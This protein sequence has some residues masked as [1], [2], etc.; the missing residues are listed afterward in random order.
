MKTAVIR[1]KELCKDFTRGKT[2]QS[3]LQNLNL[4]IFRGDFT[5]IMGSSGAGKSTLLYNISTMDIPT[6]GKVF[7]TDKE[8][9]TLSETEICNLRSKYIAFVFQS[10]NLL[11]D[12]TA[13]E[14][15]AFPAY[16][17]LPKEKANQKAAE[18]LKRFGMEQERNKYPSELSGGQQQRIAIARALAASPDIIFADEPTGA[19]NSSSGEAVL[20]MLT[21]LSETGQSI[22]MVTHDIKACA[23][24]NRLLFL[25]DGNINGDLELGQYTPEARIS[26]ENTIFQFLKSNNW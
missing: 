15:I 20:D 13:F 9:S 21:E 10:S 7:I 22:V 16:N 19:L 18:L 6:S 4:E 8:I 3:V 12:L 5:V 14:N 2:T 1:T 24:G 11:Y 25:T 17:A 26:R 23:R